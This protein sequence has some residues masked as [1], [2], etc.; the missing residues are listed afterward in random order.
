MRSRPHPIAY[1]H[2]Y[3]W[4]ILGIMVC[5]WTALWGQPDADLGVRSYRTQQ[6]IMANIEHYLE[7]AVEVDIKA[8]TVGWNAPL[9]QVEKNIRS[10]IE[11]VAS[12][13]EMEGALN[14]VALSAETTALL[15]RVANLSFRDLRHWRMAD[16]LSEAEQWYVM[17]Q[18]ALD[19]VR[20]QIGLDLNVH[21]NQTLMDALR[22][23]DVPDGASSEWL[24][25][26]EGRSLPAMDWERSDA[27]SSDLSGTDASVWPAPSAD[28]ADMAVILERI[29]QLIENQE[30]R[31]RQLETGSVAP[32][33][34][35]GLASGALRLPEFID[36]SFY[37]GSAKLTLGA[38]LQLNEII[39]VM[40]RHPQVRVVC[41][42]YADLP[43]NRQFNLTLSRRR[44][45]AVR[46]YL[47]QSGIEPARA[48][49]NFFGEERASTTGPSDRR[50]EV[51]FYLN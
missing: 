28:D 2:L 7:G 3:C 36:V 22:S 8:G 27:T 26:D 50:V 41:T 30:S 51:R 24:E 42:G 16:G 5:S 48:L 46:A 29:L 18:S 32:S 49:L 13:Q 4:F 47:L 34:P 33:G 9:R 12:F 37:T 35:A 44:A 38:Q 39:E 23:S 11:H 20:L 43:G 21:L 6:L 17:V 19:E 31:L 15:E 25:I 45:E 1:S 14:D 40:G 10:V